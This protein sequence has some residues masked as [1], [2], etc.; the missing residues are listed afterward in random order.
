MPWSWQNQ[1]ARRVARDNK[2]KAAAA[3]KKDGI[4]PR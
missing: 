4:A 3:A 1:A 2:A